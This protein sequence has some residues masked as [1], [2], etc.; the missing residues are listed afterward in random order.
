MATG[1]FALSTNNV[2]FC[3]FGGS[4]PT[5][6]I[7]LQEVYINPVR[8]MEVEYIGGFYYRDINGRIYKNELSN[9][10][11]RTITI[12]YDYT[13]IEDVKFTTL[14]MFH[15]NGTKLWLIDGIA[16][17]FRWDSVG[18]TFALGDL[19]KTEADYPSMMCWNGYIVD[20]SNDF[21]SST[22]LENSCKIVFAVNSGYTS[23]YSYSWQYWGKDGGTYY[24]G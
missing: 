3:Q 24:G 17:V 12:S 6:I 2:Y 15:L 14:Q 11:P 4:P 23:E 10:I 5:T 16:E 1:S 9:N 18:N 20:L 21:Y 8:V 7:N 13:A 19:Y 22:K